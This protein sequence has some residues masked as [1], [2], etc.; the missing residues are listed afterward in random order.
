MADNTLLRTP[1]ARIAYANTLFEARAPQNGGDK[2]F[3]C[4]LV[5]YPDVQQTPEF[6]N[7]AAAFIEAKN[8]KFGKDTKAR[9]KSPFLKADEYPAMGDFPAGSVFIRIS[10]KRRPGIVDR[11]P[12]REIVDETEL[13]SG[14]WVRA[15]LSC[16]A[17]DRP[18][19][20]GVSFGLQNVQ[21]LAD[22][23][24]LSSGGRKAEDDFE[25][26]TDEATNA[27]LESIF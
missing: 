5:F 11:D 15:T 23:E 17:Y 26:V 20:K 24:P 16:Y 9:I 1:K 10:S 7:L 25:A 22:G 18:E 4:S 13:W 19:N 14:C 21:K 27:D 3:S 8:A 12:K 6:K 2:K